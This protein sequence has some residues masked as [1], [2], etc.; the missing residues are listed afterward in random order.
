[1]NVIKKKCQPLVALVVRDGP[2]NIE[3]GSGEPVTS[4]LLGQGME[5]EICLL[6]LHPHRPPLCFDPFGFRPSYPVFSY[7]VIVAA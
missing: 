2:A 4:I 5:L 6:M 3:W 7:Q 1:M